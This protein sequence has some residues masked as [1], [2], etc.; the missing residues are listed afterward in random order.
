MSLRKVMEIRKTR[1]TGRSELF[2]CIGIGF[3]AGA[4]SFAMTNLSTQCGFHLG[5]E[6]RV[7]HRMIA[8]QTL[9]DVMNIAC[10]KRGPEQLPIHP[11]PFRIIKIRGS[12]SLKSL[13]S[14]KY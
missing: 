5:A 13:R 11:L 3:A 12:E 8:G 10:L 4:A 6:L 1:K 9:P 2:W 7:T 14:R